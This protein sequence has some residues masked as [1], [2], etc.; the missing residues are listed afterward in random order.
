MA[1]DGGFMFSSKT[2]LLKQLRWKTGFHRIPTPFSMDEIYDQVIK[3]SI[4]TFSTFFPKEMKI[5]VDLNQIRV[6]HDRD[7]F[8]GDISDIYQIP[9]IFPPDSDRFIV[10]IQ[11]LDP[12]NDMRYQALSSTYETIESYQALAIA[13]GA[14]NL[15]S[16]I[17]PPVITEFIEPNRFR[18]STGYYYRDRVIL[19]L[20]ISYSAE[21]F[22]IPRK[23][24]VAF[25]KLA[26]LDTE[27]FLYE[28]LKFEENT[29]TAFADMQLFVNRY[30]NAAQERAELLNKWST[31]DSGLTRLVCQYF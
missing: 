14:A 29:P 16:V 17:E 25:S 31:R 13:Q 8:Q 5:P 1:H 24:R 27:V 19:T 4:Q 2:D 28:S 23:Y 26:L 21:A 20:E 9:D 15:A 3:S 12:Y 10:G 18:L 6:P 11:K 30:E 22:D 7:A